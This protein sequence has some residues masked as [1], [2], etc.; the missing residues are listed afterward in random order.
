MP[1]LKDGSIVP[2][3]VPIVTGQT[4]DTITARALANPWKCTQGHIMGVIERVKT[5]HKST[6]PRLVLFRGALEPE[7]PANHAVPFAKVDSA[8]VVCGICGE[9]RTWFPGDEFIEIL[10][11]KK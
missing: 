8:E 10:K 4:P 6:R 3:Q 2:S 11:G 9:I 7:E 1:I 5:D